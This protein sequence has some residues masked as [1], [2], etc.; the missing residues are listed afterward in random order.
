VGSLWQVVPDLF[1]VRECDVGLAGRKKGVAKPTVQVTIH[2]VDASQASVTL[3]VS[4]DV[5]PS[6]I[7]T[8]GLSVS[9]M[10]TMT[11]IPR[12]ADP[13]REP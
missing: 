2:R 3:Q 4:Y 6:Q 11:S 5:G 1:P 13:L 9:G 12:D 7:L 8:N 10:T